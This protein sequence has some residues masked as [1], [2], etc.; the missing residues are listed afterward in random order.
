MPEKLVLG[1]QPR[2]QPVVRTAGTQILGRRGES[3]GGGGSGGGGVGGAGHG[4]KR[5]AGQWSGCQPAE[6]GPPGQL[7][8]WRRMLPGHGAAQPDA[9]VG[10]YAVGVLAPERPEQRLDLAGRHGRTGVCHQQLDPAGRA[11]RSGDLDP[12]AA[13]VVP[14]AVVDQVEGE[15]LQHLLKVS[16]SL[17]EPLR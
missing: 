15:P 1:G 5:G 4:H 16:A 3:G 14:D 6:H 13:G 9:A 17:A 11:W 8:R 12:A 2:K 7:R 10:A